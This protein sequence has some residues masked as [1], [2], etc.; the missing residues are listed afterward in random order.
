MGEDLHV[1]GGTVEGGED[2]V[3]EEEVEVTSNRGLEVEVEALPDLHTAM[4]DIQVPVEIK[5]EEEVPGIVIPEISTILGIGMIMIEKTEK[6]K[7]LLTHLVRKV[8]KNVT[9]PD[10]PHQPEVQSVQITEIQSVGPV[11]LPVIGQEVVGIAVVRGQGID[12]TVEV[13]ACQCREGISKGNSLMKVH[14]NF[15]MIVMNPSYL[16]LAD[17]R[18]Q[19]MTE[20]NLQIV[21]EIG[22]LHLVET[23]Q[24]IF[25]HLAVVAAGTG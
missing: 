22:S 11:A 19:I 12:V 13:P 4:K 6:A 17:G 14:Q 7:N 23:N 2:L 5:V 9:G 15:M 1:A 25:T 16:I 8:G 3:L 21:E 18:V 10:R 20:M 24:M